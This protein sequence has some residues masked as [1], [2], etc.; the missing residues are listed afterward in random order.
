[1]I[2]FGGATSVVRGV[3]PDVG[4]GYAG[5][6]SLD[7]TGLD[8]VLEI[9]RSSRA[10][11]LQAGIW[12]PALEAELKPRGLTLRHFS[13]SFELAIV[14]GMIATPAGGH[15]ATLYTHIDDFVEDV[16]MLTP[17]G[18]M[19]SRRLRGSG[20]GPSPDRMMI[21]SEG[22]LG[23]ITEAWL[24]LQDRPRKRAGASVL[25]ADF[26]KPAEAVR[27]IAQAR[28]YPGNLRLLDAGEAA[29][30]SFGDGE[31]S[32]LVLAF[33]SAD[34]ELDAWIN[35]ALE[36]CRDFGGCAESDAQWR[37]SGHRAGAA[38]PWRDAYVSAA[39]I[40]DT[41]D[42]AITWERFP[43]FYDAIK[44]ASL[45]VIEEVTGRPGRVTCRFTHVYPDGLAPCSLFQALGRHGALAEHWLAIKGAAC[46][47]IEQQGG[48]VTH[49]HAV[50]R[51][52][53]PWYE[54]QMPD[55]FGAALAG[56]KS[57]L[58]PAGLL[59]PGVLLPAGNA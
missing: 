17:V 6:L 25:F 11:R 20:A 1:M 30:N 4:D 15:F 3:E 43:S 51:D 27:V 39:I 48:I 36:V 57:R 45:K 35:R 41:F 34:H 5:T 12:V 42:T 32:V 52:H 21:G 19:E 46:D 47:A 9:D 29:A 58:D 54:K 56:A 10:V 24:R 22:A 16:R 18:I 59:N 40:A 38:G 8:R 31:G 44:T 37:N 7:V 2:P 53:M 14:C 49:H 26:F 28:L 23:I 50:G 13:Q 55:S 33:E